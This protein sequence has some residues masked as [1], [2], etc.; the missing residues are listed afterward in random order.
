MTSNNAIR[1]QMKTQGLRIKR[2]NLLAATLSGS[3]LVYISIRFFSYSSMG[4]LAGLAVGFI[5]ANGFEYCL[6]RFLLHSG[7]GIFAKQ[8]MVHHTTLSAP[9]A[10]RYV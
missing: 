8:H 5:Y 6:H 3:V 7:R 1:S 10:P 2:N 9:E 4:I